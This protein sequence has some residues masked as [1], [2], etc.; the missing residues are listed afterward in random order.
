MEE[1]E[2]KITVADKANLKTTAVWA[3]F[4]AVVTFIVLGMGIVGM[5]FGLLTVWVAGSTPAM[6]Q[7]YGSMGRAYYI[8]LFSVCIIYYL[9]MF[10][11]TLY[12]YRFAN[13]SQ[14]AVEKDDEAVMSQSLVNLRKYFKFQGIVLIVSLGLC[15][16]IIFGAIIGGMASAIFS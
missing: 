15:V 4:I 3:R 10:L 11:P 1:K 7:A 13:Q 2:L 6:T 9:V 16:L 8:V 14:D 12:M 5:L